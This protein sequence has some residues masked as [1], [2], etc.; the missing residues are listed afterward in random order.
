[1]LR[2]ERRHS[3]IP[4]TILFLYSARI[5]FYIHKYATKY[6]KKP[7]HLK[8]LYIRYSKEENIFNSMFIAGFV[9]VKCMLFSHFNFCLFKMLFHVLRI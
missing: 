6:S 2:K 4:V 5:I 8:H 3:K 7:M 9:S 1:M